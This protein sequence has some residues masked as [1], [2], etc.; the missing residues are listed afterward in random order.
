MIFEAYCGILERVGG[1]GNDAGKVIAATE[2]IQLDAS[3]EGEE[4]EGV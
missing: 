1:Q 3:E 2:E 4:A